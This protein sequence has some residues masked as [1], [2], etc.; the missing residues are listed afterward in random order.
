MQES[1]RQAAASISTDEATAIATDAY[2]FGYQLVTMEYTRRGITNHTEPTGL[3]APMG[4]LARLRE[5]PDAAFRLVTA[6]NADTLYV[7]GWIDVSKEP[8][9]LGMPD[10]QGR[11][12]LFPMLDAWTTVFQVPGTRTTGDG[13]QEYAIT[14]PNWSGTLPAGV[15]EYKSRTAL[16]WFIGRVYCIGTPEDYSAVHEFQNKITLVPLS[17]YGKAYTPPKGIVDPSIDIKT[18]PRAQVNALDASTYF[19]LMA[20]LMKDNP[21]AAEDAPMMERIAK[22]GVVPGEPFDPTK[23]SPAAL[24]ALK[25]VPQTAQAKITD[26]FNTAGKFENGWG[27]FKTTG[28]YGTDYL[29]RALITYF[30]LGAN[31]PQDAIYPT[32][33]ADVEGKP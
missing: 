10:A 24:Q 20:Q 15:T 28:V 18:A 31:R 22:I 8:Y 17:S 30:G 27:F 23:L 4:Q 26:Y 11:Y 12:Y 29:N 13:A 19:S 2:I 1:S 5:Y 3:G 9:V 21:P 32:S 33:Q 7:S 16:V 14:G 6:P 25:N